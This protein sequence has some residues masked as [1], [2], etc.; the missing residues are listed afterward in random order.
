MIEQE[1]TYTVKLY[2]DDALVLN[3]SG[4]EVQPDEIRK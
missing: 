4:E 1:D 3:E 2:E